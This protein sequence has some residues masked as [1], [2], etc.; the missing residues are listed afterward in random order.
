MFAK[1]CC[2]LNP[3]RCRP[4]APDPRSGSDRLPEAEAATGAQAPGDALGLLYHFT[5][6][7]THFSVCEKD[8]KSS[9]TGFLRR[10]E[11]SSIT[12]S[13]P[14]GGRQGIPSSLSFVPE[15]NWGISSLLPRG[16][17]ED[18]DAVILSLVSVRGKIVFE[19]RKEKRSHLVRIM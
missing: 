8:S 2:E 19:I 4:S 7:C 18:A 6:L 1:G 9:L 11:S 15:P 17:R 5:S 3:T 12:S 13:S 14:P 10:F 16:P